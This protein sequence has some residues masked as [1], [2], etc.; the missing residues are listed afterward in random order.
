MLIGTS[1]AIPRLG[2]MSDDPYATYFADREQYEREMSNRATNLQVAAVHSELADR[3][4]ALA[5]VFGAKSIADLA[6]EQ[7]QLS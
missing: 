2:K 5:V 6:A 7:D 3:Y 4:E 1:N